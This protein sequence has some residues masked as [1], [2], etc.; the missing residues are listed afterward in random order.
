MNVAKKIQRKVLLKE[1][2]TRFITGNS[3]VFQA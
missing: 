3:I 2:A 1:F